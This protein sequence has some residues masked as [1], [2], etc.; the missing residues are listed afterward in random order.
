MILNSMI[1]A[2]AC[3]LNC[4]GFPPRLLAVNPAMAGNVAFD[5]V[6]KNVLIGSGPWKCGN[7]PGN[8]LNSSCTTTHTQSANS[9]T[10]VRNG[11]G[12]MP[13]FPGTYFRSSGFL[14]AWLWSGDISPGT[15]NFS[16]AK[17]CFGVTPLDPLSASPP[18]S[19]CGR[20]Q[21]GIGTNG[22][23]TPAGTGGCPGAPNTAPCGI[24]VGSDQ[25]SIVRLYININWVYPYVWNSVE[26]PQG[27][28]PLDPVLY[29]GSGG[30]LKPASGTGGVGCSNPYS[31]TSTT[32]GG[33]DC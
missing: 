22:A 25:L 6:A 20:W 3:A 13:G 26:A 31:P 8:D 4:D 10:F 17:A 28:I 30:T 18:A 33:Y 1:P 14:A 32:P 15:Y 24:P 9:Y 5:P 7:S 27:I 2:P 11:K 23:T 29:A 21:Q 12:I 19:A 16:A